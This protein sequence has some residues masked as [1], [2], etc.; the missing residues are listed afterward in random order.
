MARKRRL[1]RVMEEFCKVMQTI[2]LI[3]VLSGLALSQAVTVKEEGTVTVKEEERV[4]RDG[5]CRTRLETPSAHEARLSREAASARA[6]ADREAALQAEQR[7]EQREADKIAAQKREVFSA[8]PEGQRE[9]KLEYEEKQKQAEASAAQE[10]AENELTHKMWLVKH[11]EYNQTD[12]ND[13]LMDQYIDAHDLNW[14]KTK[15][16]DKAFKALSKAGL[17][18]GR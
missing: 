18:V 13:A 15:S 5:C 10:R 14:R 7:A 17:L 8:T 12:A 11:P 9:A 4:Y 6:K 2:M 1:D 16:Y 3:L